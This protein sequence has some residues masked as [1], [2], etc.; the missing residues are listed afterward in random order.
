MD[1]RLNHID[2]KVTAELKSS[3]YLYAPLWRYHDLRE[4]LP[5]RLQRN[6][7]AMLS[8][9]PY[10][11]MLPTHESTCYPHMNQHA[12]QTY[13]MNQHATHTC[14]NMLP[15]YVYT[16]YPHLNQHYPPMNQHAT[17]PCSMLPA[18]YQHANRE[19]ADCPSYTNGEVQFD[20]DFWGKVKFDIS[21]GFMQFKTGIIWLDNV[22]WTK[23]DV[24]LNMVRLTLICGGISCIR[25]NIWQL[26]ILLDLI[27][28][29]RAT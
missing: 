26:Y 9:M 10:I 14:I 2:L 16:C 20:L 13:H 19:Y 6:S 29:K 22:L 24:T 15:T 27:T 1:A 25:C 17:H 18:L 3:D 8:Y 11:N 7:E 21:L 5:N 12:T 23:S 28:I 4:Q